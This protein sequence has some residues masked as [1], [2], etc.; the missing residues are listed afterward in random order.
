MRTLP[1]LALLVAMTAIDPHPA[2]AQTVRPWCAVFPGGSGGSNCGFVSHEQCMMTATPGTGAYCVPNP[3][4]VPESPR[5]TGAA[6]RR[7]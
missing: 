6:T 2:A 5:G 3:R 1:A 7:R 4:Y